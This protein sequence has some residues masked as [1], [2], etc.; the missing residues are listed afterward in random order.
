[1]HLLNEPSSS[2]P[3]H[4]RC[5]NGTP[6]DRPNIQHDC[7]LCLHPKTGASASQSIFPIDIWLKLHINTTRET[8]AV[9]FRGI[10]KLAR[11]WQT[12]YWPQS[13]V[14]KNGLQENLP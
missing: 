8:N 9:L 13:T 14:T 12:G 5:Q 11:A 1:M 6:C 3:S 2:Y 7:P 4:L 10:R